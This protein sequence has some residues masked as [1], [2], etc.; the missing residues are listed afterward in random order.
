MTEAKETP[1]I[2]LGSQPVRG[3]EFW[4]IWPTIITGTWSE[5]YPGELCAILA[6]SGQVFEYGFDSGLRIP[7]L[8]QR[9]SCLDR[10]AVPVIIPEAARDAIFKAVSLFNKHY[11]KIARKRVEVEKVEHTSLRMKYF[12]LKPQGDDIYALASRLAIDTYALA[13][14][15]VDPKLAKELRAWVDLERVGR[16]KRQEGSEGT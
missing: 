6:P 4:A 12:V 14:E 9:G 11:A 13:V 10:R 8:G 5:V 3:G 2:E 16:R 1:F 15:D 7:A